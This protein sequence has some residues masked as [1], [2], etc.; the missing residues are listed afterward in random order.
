L[1]CILS[2]DR[3]ERYT[4]RQ[5]EVFKLLPQNGR[6]IDTISL[7]DQFFR[8]SKYRKPIHR[9]IS[10]LGLVNSL[11]EKVRRNKEPF[12]IRKTKRRGPHPVHVWVEPQ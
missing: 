7:A 11:S 3:Q 2:K 9:R 6:R 4:I 5:R 1:A 10:V 8:R 12:R